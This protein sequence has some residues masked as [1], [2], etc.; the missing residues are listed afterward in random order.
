MRT[1][2]ITGA[3]GDD[4]PVVSTVLTDHDGETPATALTNHTVLS[5]WDWMY[6]AAGLGVR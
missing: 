1:V 5:E 4:G 2:K 3:W 6:E